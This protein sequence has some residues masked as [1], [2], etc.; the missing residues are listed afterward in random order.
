MYKALVEPTLLYCCSVWASA[1]TKK[2]SQKKLRSIERQFN[3]LTSKSFKTADSGALS[4]LTGSMPV[5]YMVLEIT[6]RRILL[7]KPNEFS[8]GALKATSL[9]LQMVD[10]ILLGIEKADS[11]VHPHH[12][13]A[14]LSRRRPPSR[15]KKAVISTLEDLWSREWRESSQGSTTR[16]FFPSPRCF[17]QLRS[18]YPS[19]QVMQILSGHSLLNSHKFR[20]KLVSSPSCACTFPCESILSLTVPSMPI[21][22]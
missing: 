20:L 16:L 7:S 15:I 17:T 22:V 3:I 14:S 9:H 1:I 8:P 6:M 12:C 19:Q 10:N 11:K 2:Q 21:S 13:P 4:V 18:K 5:D